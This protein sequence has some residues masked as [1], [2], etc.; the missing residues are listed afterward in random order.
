MRSPALTASLTLLLVAASA[1]WIGPSSAATASHYADWATYHGGTG[2]HGY[3][4]TMP[5]AHGKPRIVK[6]LNL[7]GQVYASPI[8]IGGTVVVA[9]E[10]NTVY[11]FTAHFHRLW[12]RHLGPPSPGGERPC[13]NIDPLGITGTPIYDRKHNSIY[14]APEAARERRA[15]LHPR[16]AD[17]RPQAHHHPRR[18]R[19]QRLPA[20]APSRVARLRQRQGQVAAQPRPARRRRG[21]D[22]GARR[23]DEI[24]FPGL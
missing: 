11:A 9:T 24:R 17:L 10:N 5:H 19:F 6:K 13:G 18:A 8:V 2:R 3:A 22:A 21:H 14:V 23:A 12:K 15:D 16:D 4:A 20:A 7:D 1:A